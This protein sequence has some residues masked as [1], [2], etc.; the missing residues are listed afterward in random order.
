M[1]NT[2]VFYGTITAQSNDL[3]G[4]ITTSIHSSTAVA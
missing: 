4:R 3:F 1:H 2:V